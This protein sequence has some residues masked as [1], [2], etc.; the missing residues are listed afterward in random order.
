MDNVILNIPLSLFLWILGI[1]L[2]IIG[3]IISVVYV[4][5]KKKVDDVEEDLQDYKKCTDAR[6][7]ALLINLTKINERVISKEELTKAIDEAVEKQFFKFENRLFK[8]GQLKP[9]KKGE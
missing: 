2:A 3:A 6:I 1:L 4:N 8:E 9:H 5:L 7:E